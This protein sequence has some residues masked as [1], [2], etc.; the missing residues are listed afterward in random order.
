MESNKKIIRAVTDLFG[1]EAYL[2][3]I[4]NRKYIGGVVFKDRIMLT[5]LNNIVHPVVHEDFCNWS[6]KFKSKPYVIEEAAVLFES[7]AAKKMDYTIFVKANVKVRVQRV[8]L[9]D[10]LSDDDVRARIENQLDD[11]EKQ[12]LADFTICN[13]NNS[14]ILPQ[15]VDLH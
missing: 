3:G 12:K 14:M 5:Q 7:G 4:L 9:R 6:L 2:E 11:N 13:E 8:M 10:E 1:D 15:I